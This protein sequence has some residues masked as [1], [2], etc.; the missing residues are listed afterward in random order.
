MKA[1][2]RIEE[3]DSELSLG[4]VLLDGYIFSRVF[5]K[6]DLSMEPTIQQ[7]CMLCD[8]SRHV[9]LCTSRNVGKTVG[10]I[11]RI[12]RYLV[13]YLPE[14]PDTQEEILVCTPA[15]A[16]LTPL[17]D[18]L[19][20]MMT[21]NP[22]FMSLVQAWNRG[23]KP[24]IITKTGL[25]MQARIEGSSGT[26][27]NMV[28]IHPRAVF[29][30]E[31]EYSSQ[32]CHRSR[33]GGAMP[34]TTWVYAGV[35]NGVRGTP[36]YLLD[37]TKEGRSWSRHKF[38]MLSANP[39]F[40]TSKKYRHEMTDAFG[41]KNSPDYI[42]QVRGEWGDEAMS[43][44][45]PGSI[46]WNPELPY[47]IAN[48]TG[49]SV[50]EHLTN[51]SL[52]ALLRIPQ[53]Q[54]M[55]AAIGWDFGFSPDPSTFVLGV[56]YS[57]E[58]PWKTYARVTLYQTMLPKQI[59]VLKYIWTFVLNNKGVLISIDSP[60]C[61]QMLLADENN[62]MFGDRVRLTNQGGTVEM[63]TVTG[64]MVTESMQSDPE[65]QQHRKDG[66]V[67]KV[68]RKYFLTEQWRKMMQ[69]H[70]LK[71]EA[72]T[73][74]EMG[75]DPELES[76]LIATIERRQESGYV[77]YEVPKSKGSKITQ[78]QAT[79]GMRALVDCIVEIESQRITEPFDVSGMISAL[80]WGG[81]SN[82]E[83]KYRAPWD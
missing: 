52:P 56:K 77:T 73:R 44:F 36:F 8:N 31:A 43:S 54:C 55:K 13:T 76:E 45:P 81:K 30:D 57:D 64:R 37:Q 28:G 15:E 60:E 40:L 27:T 69:N 42:T 16:H 79:D 2:R 14:R 83:D 59:D 29:L 74:L 6:A 38:S 18:R 62:Y 41:G 12:L 48:V 25:V 39:R 10:M 50:T 7:K 21:K 4:L 68:R 9:L 75:F 47:Y 3:N 5:Q 33:M 11:G 61:Y 23:D 71:A 22:F 17:I 53:V 24:K 67:A 35:P 51:N 19:F 66:K 63:D 34:E 49:A 80:G 46:S 1:R 26:D 65:F 20:A 70:M 82:V 58:Q 72:E 32:I 78:D